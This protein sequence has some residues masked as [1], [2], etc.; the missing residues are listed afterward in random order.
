MRPL[1]GSESGA[2]PQKM[3][4]FLVPKK[5]S[6]SNL[7]TPRLNRTF[8]SAASREHMCWLSPAV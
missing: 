4:D 6:L 7:E 1:T 3:R 5:N 2:C 8:L